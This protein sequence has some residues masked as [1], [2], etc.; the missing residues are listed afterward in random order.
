MQTNPRTARCVSWDFETVSWIM[1][2]CTIA[3]VDN[4]TFNCSC[5]HLTNFAVLIVSL[6]LHSTKVF[7]YSFVFL[8]QD[9]CQRAQDCENDETLEAILSAITFVGVAISCV[10]LVITIITLLVFRYN[11]CHFQ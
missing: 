4:T 5:T 9:I 3:I 8:P 1:D 2:G 6:I 10:G 7:I 11:N